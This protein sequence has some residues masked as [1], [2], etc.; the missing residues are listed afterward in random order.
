MDFDAY[1]FLI[2]LVL[3]TIPALWFDTYHQYEDVIRIIELTI[4]SCVLYAAFAGKMIFY[5]HFH[6]TYNYMVHYGNHA[7]KRN[8]IDIFFNQDRGALVLLGFI[9]MLLHLGIWEHYSYPC[10]PFHIQSLI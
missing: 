9:P 3:V 6:D 1:I 8:L 4:Y 10:R 2:S 5:K 7:E